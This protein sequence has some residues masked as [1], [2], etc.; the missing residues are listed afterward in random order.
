MNYFN[1]NKPAEQILRDLI[2]ATNGFLVPAEG[3]LFGTPVAVTPL[4]GDRQQR[5]TTI[6]IEMDA[7]MPWQNLTGLQ[8]LMYKRPSLADFVPV[9]SPVMPIVIASYPVTIWELLPQI[10]AYYGL[11]LTEADVLNTEYD[12]PVY[13]IVMY[14][15]P[16]SVA[17]TGS[18]VLNVQGVIAPVPPTSDGTSGTGSDGTTTTPPTTPTSDGTTPPTGDP[19][20]IDGETGVFF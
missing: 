2:F 8:T 12:A 13:P 18:V 14:A 1:F 17:F 5:N 4:L 7:S 3:V 15:A 11:Q 10:N 9:Q 20:N 19:F 16:G 6:T